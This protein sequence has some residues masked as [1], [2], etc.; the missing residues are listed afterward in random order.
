MTTERRLIE[1]LSQ[2]QALSRKERLEGMRKY[3][4]E[5][6]NAFG[7]T[8]PELRGIAKETGYDHLLASELWSTGIHEA[9]ILASM[10]ENPSVITSSQMD[11][12]AADFDSWDLCDQC[13]G[14]L[15]VATPFAYGK[16]RKWSSDRRE[17]VKRA[18]FSL[19]A[20]LAARDRS[21]KDSTFV[22]LLG[23]IERESTDGRNYVRKAVNWAL[24]QIGKRSPGLNEA[25]I[26]LS[27]QLIVNGHRSA[28]WIARSA[29]RELQSESVIRRMKKR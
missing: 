13:C 9:R 20:C 14:N 29:I 5:T 7:I 19:M 24:R 16:V 3:G 18:G 1:I 27:K 6:A 12:W 28:R 25:A 4:I 15:F 17:F 26:G 22:D 21:E 2:M 11:K 8:I 23:L 10:V